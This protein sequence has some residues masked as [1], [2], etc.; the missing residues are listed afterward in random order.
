[1]YVLPEQARLVNFYGPEA[2]NYDEDELLAR[3]ILMT[4]DMVTLLRLYEP[5]R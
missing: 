1:M 3:C 2:E 5:S 4:R